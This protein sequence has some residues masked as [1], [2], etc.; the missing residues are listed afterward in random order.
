[1]C[2]CVFCFYFVL[3]VYV[4]KHTLEG[5]Q[6]QDVYRQPVPGDRPQRYTGTTNVATKTQLLPLALANLATGALL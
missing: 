2:L 5:T 4:S 6:E 3:C 1:M